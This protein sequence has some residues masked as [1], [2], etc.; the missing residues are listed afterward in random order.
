MHSTLQIGFAC[1]IAA[2]SATAAQSQSLSEGTWT[3]VERCGDN[4]V[5]KDPK[6]KP[7]FERQTELIVDKGRI[8]GHDRTVRKRDGAVTQASY[9]GK[10]EGSKITVNGTGLRSDNKKPWYY[11]Y[12]GDTTVDGRAELTGGIF[13]DRDSAGHPMLM[14]ACRLTF[15]SLKDNAAASAPPAKPPK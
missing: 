4:T 11:L 5:T 1:L 8:A 9:D 6:L 15:M 12:E 7:G 2:A 14:R 3:V 13:M 10:I